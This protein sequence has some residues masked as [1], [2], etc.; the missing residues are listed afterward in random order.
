MFIKVLIVDPMLQIPVKK[1]INRD[2]MTYSY[3]IPFWD[4]S[5]KLKRLRK[6][7]IQNRL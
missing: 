4:E 6:H 3:P 2:A 7:D 1:N 5:Q